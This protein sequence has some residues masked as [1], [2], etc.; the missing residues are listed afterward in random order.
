MPSSFF[1]IVVE[2]LCHPE[3]A[4]GVFQQMSGLHP[5]S[6]FCK[7]LCCDKVCNSMLWIEDT[8]GLAR[9]HWRSVEKID[10]WI[11]LKKGL[12]NSRVPS[13]LIRNPGAFHFSIPPENQPLSKRSI[14]KK[15][16]IMRRKK[17]NRVYARGH[18]YVLG[19]SHTRFDGSEGMDSRF[20]LVVYI[21]RRFL[22]RI[23]LF[24]RA[25]FSKF[26]ISARKM[27]Y[28]ARQ[29]DWNKSSKSLETSVYRQCSHKC[30]VLKQ[31]ILLERVW[32][33]VNKEVKNC[34]S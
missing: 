19:S 17:S 12:Y 8:T 28:N 2:P 1:C 16:V 33:F 14:N 18:K 4:S 13:Y 23:V 22:L 31:R 27:R 9:R 25:K 32:L 10:W 6:C 5:L 26:P 30:I 29:S 20:W 34:V 24:Q 21:V 3:L 11:L 7:L 15:L